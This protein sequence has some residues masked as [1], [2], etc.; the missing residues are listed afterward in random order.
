MWPRVVM[1]VRMKTAESVASPAHR[2]QR[3]PPAWSRFPNNSF[4]FSGIWK[5]EVI[6]L[7]SLQ[8]KG[9][10]LLYG[11]INAVLNFCWAKSVF[12]SMA[13]I[14]YATHL[15]PER[16]NAEWMSSHYRRFW[17]TRIPQLLWIG[18]SIPWWSIRWAWW[19][20]WGKIS[21]VKPQYVPLNIIFIDYFSIYCSMFCVKNQ[22]IQCI[23][24]ISSMI[25]SYSHL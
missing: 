16:S 10:F 8:T 5:K 9:K 18:M 13:F 1:T 2:R 25:F 24:G 12:Q 23:I 14:R 17:D 3:T 20:N 4:P 19:I 15:R 6:L 11:H 21:E 22:Y 7:S